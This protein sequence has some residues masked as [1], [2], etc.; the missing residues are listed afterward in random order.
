MAA[1]TVSR[2]VKAPAAEMWDLLVDWPRHAGWVPLTSMRVD[3]N[4]G[5]GVGATF[6]GRTALGPLGF[7]DLMRVE[8]WRPP[9]G[10]TVGRLRVEHL[11]R[12]VGGVAGLEVR[13]VTTTR[14]TVTWWEDMRLLPGL[15]GRLGRVVTV[16]AAP[17]TVLAGRR[18][19]ARVLRLA[20]AQAEQ[21]HAIRAAGLP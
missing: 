10:A 20:A 2:E 11:G 9:D 21:A 4:G 18:I 14:C 5:H 19:F 8:S 16:L 3:E 7:D 17:P 6:V 12:V 15:P 1:F 13:P